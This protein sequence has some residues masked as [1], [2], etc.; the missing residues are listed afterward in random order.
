[1]LGLAALQGNLDQSRVAAMDTAQ[2]MHRVRE[3]AAGMTATGF[4]PRIEVLM[5]RTTLSRNTGELRFRNADRFVVD[6]AID[7]HSF[8][9]VQSAQA[10]P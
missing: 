9:L 4:Q 3:I 5:A 6:G 7:R 2:E 8:P 10:K 1:M